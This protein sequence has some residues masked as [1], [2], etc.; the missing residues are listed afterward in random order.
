MSYFLLI[1]EGDSAALQLLSNERKREWKPPHR[2]LRWTE[3]VGSNPTRSIS[4]CC[5]TTALI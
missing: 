3:V 5:T 4:Y 2:T 1:I